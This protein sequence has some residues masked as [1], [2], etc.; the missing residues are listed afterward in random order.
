MPGGHASDCPCVNCNPTP[1]RDCGMASPGGT[2]LNAAAVCKHRR[3]CEGRQ[4][5]NAGAGV[6][7]AARHAQRLQERPALAGMRDEF[8]AEPDTGQ[9]VRA[10]R[11]GSGKYHLPSAKPGVALCGATSLDVGH[12]QVH[13]DRADFERLAPERI[14]SHCRKRD[15]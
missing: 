5:L 1:C 13:G 10:R 3:A 2:H 14:C 4:L 7:A 9:V 12:W 15:S 6:E 11:F 8:D